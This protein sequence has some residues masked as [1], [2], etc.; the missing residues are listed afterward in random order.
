MMYYC[1]AH[2][3]ETYKGSGARDNVSL[4]NWNIFYWV[5]CYSFNG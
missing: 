1:E 2:C 3:V 5:Y 4:L